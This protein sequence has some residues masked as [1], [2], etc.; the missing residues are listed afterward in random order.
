MPQYGGVHYH[1]NSVL[2]INY[3]SLLVYLVS[4]QAL[5]NIN[6]AFLL[7]WCHSLTSF[8]WWRWYYYCIHAMLFN[9]CDLIMKAIFYLYTLVWIYN[10]KVLSCFI[11]IDQIWRQTF[12]NLMLIQLDHNISLGPTGCGQLAGSVIIKHIFF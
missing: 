2:L 9:F 8:P 4:W 12:D 7:M 1:L 6:L 5:W 3:S 10:L 11:H